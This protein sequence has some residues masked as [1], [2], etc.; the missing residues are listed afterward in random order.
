MNQR[1][2]YRNLRRVEELETK[3]ISFHKVQVIHN[4]IKQVLAFGMFLQDSWVGENLGYDS[5]IR[6]KKSNK[7]K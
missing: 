1:N 7:T 2:T 5:W 3:V 4:L 6:N